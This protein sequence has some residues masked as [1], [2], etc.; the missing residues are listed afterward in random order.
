MNTRAALLACLLFTACDRVEAQ[1]N[2][3]EAPA[4]SSFDGKCGAKGLPDCPTQRWMKSTLQ[5]YQRSQ[6]YDRLATAL[7]ELATKQPAGYDEWGSIAK[8]GADAARKHDAEAVRES[9]RTC[10]DGMRDRF[11]QE[12]RQAILF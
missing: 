2:A 1:A 4:T 5:S 10:H 9:C 6:D 12:L 8:R 11:K 7:D 3:V